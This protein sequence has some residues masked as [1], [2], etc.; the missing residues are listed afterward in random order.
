M[1]YPSDLG[2]KSRVA[3]NPLISED[4]ADDASSS[5]AKDSGIVDFPIGYVTLCPYVQ[6]EV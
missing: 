4:A 1:K 2:P 3:K 5:D 6:S